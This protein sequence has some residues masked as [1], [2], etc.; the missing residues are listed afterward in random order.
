MRIPWIK[1]SSR[2]IVVAIIYLLLSIPD[3]KF[4]GVQLTKEIDQPTP[5]FSNQ[6]ITKHIAK[7]SQLTKDEKI[8]LQDTLLNTIATK[9]HTLRSE[10]L[11]NGSESIDSISAD[12]GLVTAI[13]ATSNVDYN[14]LLE[15]LWHWRQLIKEQSLFWSLNSDSERL[16]SASIL[17]FINLCEDFV[18]VNREIAFTTYGQQSIVLDSTISSADLNTGDIIVSSEDITYPFYGLSKTIPDFVP[19][20][21]LISQVSDTVF[22]ISSTPSSGL[23]LKK[24][25]KFLKTPV[26][27]IIHLRLRED[28]PDLLSNPKIP[29]LAADFA[30]NYARK[31]ITP[32]DFLLKPISYGAVSEIELLKFVYD[33]QNS[34]FIIPFSAI[35]D[36]NKFGLSSM[37]INDFD[38]AIASDIQYH[39][40]IAYVGISRN[41]IK[42]KNRNLE[43]AVE[44][45]C[46]SLLNH[47]L[48]KRLKWDLPRYRVLNGFSR[49]LKLLN[50]KTIMPDGMASE[51][52]LVY[53]Y[54]SNK[55][56]NLMPLLKKDVENF[57]TSNKYYPTYSEM[58]VMAK[59]ILVN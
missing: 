58:L 10:L 27:T 57:R 31:N 3:S 14:F 8:K 16:R 9:L 33:G 15:N 23:E 5:S 19:S 26:A 54:L 6:V 49:V 36:E 17:H 35:R 25:Q 4:Q 41:G 47:D 28:L 39:P 21:G 11:S 34:T 32:Y 48:I 53:D 13:I 59:S 46:F 7:V 56:S 29:Q 37:G 2:V 22:Y 40:S 20:L 55:K 1:I 38:Q 42:I 44:M 24:I 30:Y 12:F 18:A 52:A 45:A 50:G 43:L 51:T